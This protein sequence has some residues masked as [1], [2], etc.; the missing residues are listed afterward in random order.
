MS[1]L[2]LPNV[3]NLSWSSIL[4]L[5][6]RWL[7]LLK[8]PFTRRKLIRRTPSILQMEAVECGAASLNM[9]LGYHGYTVA[10]AE[11]R[12]ACGVSRDGSKASNV[13]NA[14]RLYKLDA[15]GFKAD[16]SAI[17]KL[18]PPYIVYWNFNHF[19]VVEGFYRDRVY[20]NDPATGPRSV[21]LAEFSESFTG[22]VLTFVPGAK[23]Q[24]GGEKPSIRRPLRYL[25]SSA[26]WSRLKSS[27]GSLM[28]CILIGFLLVLPGLATPAFSQV[29][30]DQVIL[31]GRQDWL[32]PLVIAMVITA[33]LTGLLKR[34]QLQVLRQLKVKLAISMSSRFLRHLLYLPVS[35]Y[36][37]RFA[38]EISNRTQLNDRLAQLLSGQ[39]VTTVISSVMVIFY[40]G[41]MW[42]Y[43]WVLTLIGIAF[44]ALNLIVLQLG[45]RQRMDTNMRLMQVQ[46][47]ADG[48]AIAGLQNMETL[49]ASGAESDFFTRWAGYYAKAVNARQ[50]METLN[51]RMSLLPTLL[52]SLSVMLLL[53]VGGFRVMDGVLTI[54][55]L[56]AFQSLM[57]QFMQPVGQIV[58]LGGD[59]QELTG[60]LARLDDVLKNESD[61][62][63][64]LQL[65][66]RGASQVITQPKL[67]GYLEIRNLTFGYSRTAPPLIENF[68]VSLKPGQRV[69]LVGGS[70]S[71]KS[72]IAKLVAGLYQ[73]WSGEILFDGKR[74]EEI[75]RIVLVN[76]LAMVE[77]DV[78]L[79]SGSVR[80]NLTLWDTTIP[81]SN[82]VQ[83][84]QDA[85]IQDVIMALPGGYDANLL[86]GA[87][88]LSG[89]QRQRMEIAR[90][91]VNNPPI[92]LMDEATSALDSETERI[93]SNNLR[94]RGCTCL[95][96]AH[97]LSTI[98]DCDEIIV[99]ERGKVVQRGSHDDLRR[100]P[101]HY[102]DLIR[103]EG[104][105]LETA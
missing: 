40:A 95:I 57:Q 81:D 28:F 10:L 38:G 34:M 4:N 55:K 9:I 53:V 24:R 46:G 74:R 105:S 25:Q 41:V 98:R 12:Q 60:N 58:Q 19:L 87:T 17:Q 63:V 93:I 86:E 35:F 67:E 103:S 92:L 47:K 51:Q 89:G 80:D 69:A 16:I 43:D 39:L 61:P 2:S 83:A 11:L 104:G 5:W 91:L 101:G 6:Q 77:Q 76:S 85:V 8:D 1:T 23:F 102:L 14:A 59:F 3:S 27:V 100:Q 75:P 44:V 15:E 20:L 97:R 96:V 21:S 30:I 37:Q 90:T 45:A 36:D 73:P 54:G 49:K 32:R 71:G 56:I 26:L 31:Q 62:L 33:V 78:L 42:M 68:N 72:T 18:E 13:L 88:N 79:F 52:S 94:L 66:S 65:S 29:F 84:C 99:L 82:L 48:Q 50:E 70:G 22:V 64:K 7:T